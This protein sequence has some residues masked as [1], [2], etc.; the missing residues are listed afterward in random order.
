MKPLLNPSELASF[1]NENKQQKRF[2]V[3]TRNLFNTAY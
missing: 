1:P 2:P 3:K